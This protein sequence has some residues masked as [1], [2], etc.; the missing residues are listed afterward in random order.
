M[1]E[2]GTL[3]DRIEVQTDLKPEFTNAID[4]IDVALGY[5]RR[6]RGFD[7][8]WSSRMDWTLAAPASCR[9]L[10]RSS[11]WIWLQYFSFFVAH[12]RRHLC[13]ARAVQ[14]ALS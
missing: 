7:S 13:Q 12:E 14:R 2:A 4:R 1:R 6:A 3:L 8:L 11:R 9:H 10:H 5:D